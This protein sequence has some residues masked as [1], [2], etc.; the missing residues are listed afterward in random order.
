MTSRKPFSLEESGWKDSD[1]D[2]IREKDG[3]RLE[4]EIIY[5]KGTAMIDDLALAISAQLK[6]IGMEIKVRGMEML[7]YY[8][9]T[10]KNDFYISLN[11]AYGISYDPYTFVTNMNSQLQTDFVAAQALALVKDG[12]GILKEL[13]ATA[14]EKKFNRPTTLS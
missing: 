13:N 7:D 3:V 2:G 10:M 11:R 5:M 6:E 8:A 9:E 4:G 1:G 14:D 12:N